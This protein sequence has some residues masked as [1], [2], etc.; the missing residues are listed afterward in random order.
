MRSEAA[1]CFFSKAAKTA[2]LAYLSE[3]WVA[4]YCNHQSMRRPTHGRVESWVDCI[5]FGCIHFS[6]IIRDVRWAR[7]ALRLYEKCGGAKIGRAELA[8][9]V[10]PNWAD[11]HVV[12]IDGLANWFQAKHGLIDKFIVQFSGNFGLTHDIELL[13]DAEKLLAD[14]SGIVLY[15]S[16]P[17]ARSAYWVEQMESPTISFLYRTSRGTCSVKCSMPAI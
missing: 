15:S 1:L 5:P 16:A 2:E 13:I 10:I 6:W 12:P 8:I 9:A 11:A 3:E 7:Y 17:G 14:R 4:R